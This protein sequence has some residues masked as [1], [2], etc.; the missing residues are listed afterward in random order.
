MAWIFPANEKRRR[1]QRRRRKSKRLIFRWKS[2]TEKI[3]RN[4]ACPATT[5]GVLFLLHD[6]S[7]AVHCNIFPPLQL[8]ITH[9]HMMDIFFLIA[10]EQKQHCCVICTLMYLIWHFPVVMS[11]KNQFFFSRRTGHTKI[12]SHLDVAPNAVPTHGSSTQFYVCASM[13]ST[14][15]T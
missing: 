3:G 5:F 10:K 14:R 15:H 2:K 8:Y 9:P 12:H 11:F 1:R 4:I 7:V 6:R 13:A